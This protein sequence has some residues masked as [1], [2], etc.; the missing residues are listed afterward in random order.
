MCLITIYKKSNGMAQKLSKEEFIKRAIKIH[1]NK[2]DY[3]KV[4]YNNANEKVTIICPVHGEFLQK[5][6]NH[7]N[8]KQGCPKCS[9]QSYKSTKEEFVDKAK[10]VYGDKYTYDNVEYVNNK[11][12]IK[13][14]CP[15]HGDFL[16]RPDNFLHGHACP[17]CAV[18]QRPQCRPWT[19]NEFIER[20]KSV[21]GDKY[22]YEN[23]NYQNY[24]TSVVI[25]CKKHGDFITNP[26]NFLQ[27]HGCP[28]CATSIMEEKLK[29]ALDENGI[30]Y[31]QQKTFKWLKYNGP[32][33]IDFYLPKHLIA[34][35]CQG[36]QHFKPI[37]QWGGESTFE[38]IKNRDISKKKLCE[39][40]GIEVVYY[41]DIKE[42]TPDF[43]IKDKEKLIK[44]LNEKDINNT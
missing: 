3:S 8:Q 11:T 2:Y 1:G 7:V 10:K 30:A 23:T 17:K 41:S 20:A 24:D 25:T 44:K 22:T 38:E 14:T 31:V 4:I 26:S 28:K 5:P 16:A 12:C 29:H 42:K 39:E 32:L 9:H 43:V 27:G 33:K 40:N 19:N 37:E 34:I 18:K 35:E 15:E 6:S 36:L 13:I 21:H